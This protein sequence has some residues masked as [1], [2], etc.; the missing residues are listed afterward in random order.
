MWAVEESKERMTI[1]PGIIFQEEDAE[2]MRAESGQALGELLC[3]RS[4]FQEAPENLVIRTPWKIRRSRAVLCSSR[5]QRR[6][7]SERSGAV[8]LN[9]V[10]LRKPSPSPTGAETLAL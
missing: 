3:P 10:P 7:R 1:W 9:R 5:A 8:L 2:E 6:T 4:R